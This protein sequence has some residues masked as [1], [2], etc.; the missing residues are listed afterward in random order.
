MFKLS[1]TQDFVEKSQAKLAKDPAP[2]LRAT[3]IDGGSAGDKELTTP[4]NIQRQLAERIGSDR[5]DMWFDGEQ[6]FQICHDPE[7]K[8]NVSADSPFTCQRIQS[9]LGR[10]I[11]LIVDRVC[12]P[13]FSIEY[14]VVESK[15]AQTNSSADAHGERADS[16]HAAH[17]INGATP[18]PLG[19]SDRGP[20]GNGSAAGAGNS[21]IPFSTPSF[22]PKQSEKPR[23]LSG[24]HF[25]EN[26]P[27]IEKAVEQS[28]RTPGR[29]SPLFVYDSVL[30]RQAGHIERVS[31]H[32]RSPDSQW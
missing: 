20:A 24:F 4:N 16:A 10:D 14:V 7:T 18:K 9:S 19:A 3:E 30:C 27:L 29:Y 11:R 2:H 8:V 22:K 26:N 6:N 21:T 15:P 5:F 1:S 13:Q 23:G 32:D 31:I 28:F 17:A 12:G 25:G